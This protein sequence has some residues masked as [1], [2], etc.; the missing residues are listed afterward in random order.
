VGVVATLLTTRQIFLTLP[1]HLNAGG[2]LFVDSGAFS[3][4]Q[5]RSCMDWEKVFKAYESLLDQTSQPENLS[6]VAPDVVGDQAAT[7]DLWAEHATSVKYWIASGARVIVPLQV[8]RLSA[9]DLLKRAFEIFGTSKLCAGV[10]SNLAA[11]GK[12]D[13]STIQHNDFH[14]LGRV[15]LTP[16]LAEK[17]QAI[18]DSN[19]GAELTADANWLRART[20]RISN[21]ARGLPRSNIPFD[22]R[23]SRA[24]KQL[25]E[26]DGYQ[27]PAPG[28]RVGHLTH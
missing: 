10:P 23:R 18:L 9:G 13:C 6:I 4:F 2:K 19:P 27:V 5:K 25:L 17:V 7:L 8:G 26:M 22:C 12:A 11:M 15:V 21:I 3:A 24:I 20:A 16:D 14:I 28:N 1:K